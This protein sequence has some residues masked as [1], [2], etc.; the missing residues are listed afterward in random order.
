MG[1]GCSGIF[2]ENLGDNVTLEPSSFNA[3]GDVV[4]AILADE[5]DASFIGPGPAISGFQQSNGEAVRIVS[6]WV[7][8]AATAV[9]LISA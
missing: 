2:E 1:L 5:L 3:G 4:T 6:G 9:R 7:G 8:M